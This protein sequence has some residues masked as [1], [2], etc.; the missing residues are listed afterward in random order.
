M[1][2]QIPFSIFGIFAMI[3]A[4]AS[5]WLPETLNKPVFQSIGDAEENREK[6][7]TRKCFSCFKKVNKVEDDYLDI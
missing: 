3:A 1:T 4:V 2:N 7:E 6:E 5:L